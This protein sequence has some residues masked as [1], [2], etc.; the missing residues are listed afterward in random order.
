MLDTKTATPKYRRAIRAA[1]LYK[2]H[3]VPVINR[4]ALPT[5]FVGK[6]T[7]TGVT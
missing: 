7:K 4:S 1:I 5:L 6:A 3:K 2:P